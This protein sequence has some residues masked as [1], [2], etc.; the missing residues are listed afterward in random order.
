LPERQEALEWSRQ[1][2]SNHWHLVLYFDP[3]KSWAMTDEEVARCWL[4]AFPGPLK[5]ADSL[6]MEERFVQALLSNSDRLEVLRGR[7][8]SLSW[9]MKALNDPIARMANR[10][11]GCTHGR[12]FR[13]RARSA[14]SVP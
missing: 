4:K 8:G 14:C 3:Q 2:V 7:L 1:R 13:T 10:E 11:D 9:F 12:S 5:H 6:E